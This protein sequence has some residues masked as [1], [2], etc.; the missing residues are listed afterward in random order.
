MANAK[1]ALVLLLVTLISFSCSGSAQETVQYVPLSSSS[2]KENLVAVWNEHNAGAYGDE[3]QLSLNK[4]DNV[5]EGVTITTTTKY[6]CGY[7]RASVRLP[8]GD[9]SGTVATLYLASPGP[10]HSEVDFEFLGNKTNTQP[11]NNEIVLQTNIFAT[12][13]GNREQRISLWF[14]P[15]EDFH[16]YSVIWNHKTVSMYVD[17]VLIRIFQNY[18]DQGVPY[19]RSDKAMQVYMS[20]FDGS[21]WATR[22]GLDKIDWSHSPFNVRYKDIIIDACVVDPAS[23]MASPCA[24]PEADNWWNQPYFH[25]LP[26]D[27]LAFMD[28]VMK[29][30]CI[31][32]YCIDT[33]RFPV[34]PPECTL[35]RR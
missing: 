1:P 26:A 15:T 31:Y 35:P 32:D 17:E 20:I 12:G 2:F 23:I 10:D 14:D 8:R 13:V 11:G 18:E 5:S 29:D 25:S 30:H 19:L 6:Y 27:R 24:R 4:V 22:G 21:S 34:P 33:K 28:Q 9:S 16:Y 3:V 7:F